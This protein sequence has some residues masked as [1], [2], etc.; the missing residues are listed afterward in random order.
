MGTNCAPLIADLFLFSCERDF[1]VSLSYNKET[2]IIQAFNS[3]SRYLD[4]RLNIDIA[5][6][7]GLVGRIYLLNYS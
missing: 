1:M 3:I 2:E 5:Y 4:D 7:T 6:F